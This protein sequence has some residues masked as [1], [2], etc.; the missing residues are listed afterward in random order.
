MIDTFKL[1]F[2]A[3]NLS[4]KGGDK[5]VSVDCNVDK[6]DLGRILSQIG[7][8]NIMSEFQYELFDEINITDIVAKFKQPV[9]KFIK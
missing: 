9:S 6:K 3:T 7:N 1:S 4:I 5:T 2:D 8:K